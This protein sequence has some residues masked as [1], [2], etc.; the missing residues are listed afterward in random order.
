MCLGVKSFALVMNVEFRTLGWLLMGVVGGIYSPQPLPS[1]WLFLLSMGA[2]D[3]LV[4]HW[5]VTVHCPVHA[6]S[7]RPL[8][9]GAV[10]R[11]SPLFFCCTGQSGAT[12]NSSVTSDFCALTS[13]LTS[14]RHCLQLYTFTVDCWRV[15]SR[16]STGSPDSPVNYSGARLQNSREWL[17]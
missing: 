12:P 5:T 7:A 14:A 8:G 9:F 11:W 2:P 3:S 4:A 1:R 17:V 16:C 15:G 13:A 6:T 10:D